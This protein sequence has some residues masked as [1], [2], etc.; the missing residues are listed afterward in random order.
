[1]VH[2]GLEVEE[3]SACAIFHE[4]ADVES[5]QAAVFQPGTA[6]LICTCELVSSLSISKE[7]AWTKMPL[8]TLCP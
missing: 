5:D 1:M 4:I 3:G 6:G 8:D 2:S 7:P